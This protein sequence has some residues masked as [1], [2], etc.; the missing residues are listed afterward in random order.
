MNDVL[1]ADQRITIAISTYNDRIQKAI[2]LALSI[3]DI[4]RIMIIH[5]VSYDFDTPP[6]PKGI[7]YFKLEGVGV[8]ISRNF[9]LDNA[10]SNYL[11]FLDDDVTVD[12]EKARNFIFHL[13]QNPEKFD[14][15]TFGVLDESGSPRKNYPNK[16]KGHNLISILSVGTIEIIANRDRVIRSGCYFPMDMGAG[17]D[18]PLADEPVFLAKCIKSGLKVVFQPYYFVS[19]P[20]ESSGGS[21]SSIRASRSRGV[22]FRRIYGPIAGLI[23]L[24]AMLLKNLIKGN[25]EA[26][27]FVTT[28]YSAVCGLIKDRKII[29]S[30][31]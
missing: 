24:T 13:L 12:A 18:L 6:I 29:T 19:H 4:A 17:S 16:T 30:N 21:F 5:Q 11:W 9:A 15:V 14:V 23:L 3:Q 28:Y 8:A 25:L 2:K 20:Y 27:L 31:D 22:A 10:K 26:R 7:D 1:I